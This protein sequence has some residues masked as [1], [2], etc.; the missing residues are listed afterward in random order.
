MQGLGLNIIGRPRG[1]LRGR[2][3]DPA[4]GRQK[5]MRV[6]PEQWAPYRHSQ[7]HGSTAAGARR[8][9]AS[10]YVHL[11]PALE[12]HRSEESHWKAAVKGVWEA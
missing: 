8:R 1:D 4:Q 9:R 3:H 10:A 7:L 6:C 12:A 11:L 2:R 5:A